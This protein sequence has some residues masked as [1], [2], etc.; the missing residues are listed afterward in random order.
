MKLLKNKRWYIQM[1]RYSFKIPK[2]HLEQWM[3]FWAAQK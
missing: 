1:C 2:W 3:V